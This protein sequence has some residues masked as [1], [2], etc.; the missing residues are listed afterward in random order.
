[1]S[2]ISEG[3]LDIYWKSDID[4]EQIDGCMVI[5]KPEFGAAS[6]I[7]TSG[8]VDIEKPAGRLITKYDF[9]DVFNHIPDFEEPGWPLYIIEASEKKWLIL[10]IDAWRPLVLMPGEAQSTWIYTYPVIR[11]FVSLLRNHGCEELCY[12]GATAPN[13]SFP[14]NVF[15]Q[16]KR[17]RMYEYHFGEGRKST[18]KAFL[19]PPA[20]MFPYLF[21][22]AGGDGWIGFTG[23]KQNSKDPVDYIAAGTLASYISKTLSMS[24]DKKAMMNAA[25]RIRE[26]ES[27]TLEMMEE[28]KRVAS[29]MIPKQPNANDNMWG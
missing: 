13:D 14:D 25:D 27:D 17:T 3:E 29:S 1:M 5:A 10:V 19:L 4:F 7:A 12:L 16:P 23:Y 2:R 15:G 8:L 24:P 11:D 9:Q 21:S 26:E 20:W 22:A 18:S 28:A 6:Y